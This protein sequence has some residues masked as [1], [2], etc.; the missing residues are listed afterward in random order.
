MFCKSCGNQIDN[1]STFCTF[2]GTKLTTYLR[3]QDQPTISYSK[4]EFANTI[5]PVYGQENDLT[6]TLVKVEQHNSDQTFKINDKLVQHKSNIKY[7]DF[8]L[9][10]IATIFL[11]YFNELSKLLNYLSNNKGFDKESFRGEWVTTNFTNF[12]D[13]FLILGTL[14]IILTIGML[15]NKLIKNKISLKYFF[16]R[17]LLYTVTLSIFAI[18]WP[19][20]KDVY[21]WISFL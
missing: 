7:V 2:C 19:Y 15:T 17:L 10:G 12:K 8:F 20:D 6:N 3:P 1:D 18:S 9:I 4:Q 13:V 11:H 14:I 5:Q 16:I 21:T